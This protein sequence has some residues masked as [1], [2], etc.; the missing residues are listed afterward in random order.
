M[1]HM[2]MPGERVA[3]NVEIVAFLLEAFGLTE[4]KMKLA[5]Q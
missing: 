3:E 5:S 1:K 4:S 2:R